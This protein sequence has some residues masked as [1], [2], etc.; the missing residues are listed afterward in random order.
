MRTIHQ[1][2]VSGKD[3]SGHHATRFS[4]K[5]YTSWKAA[6]AG[7]PYFLKRLERQYEHDIGCLETIDPDSMK[8]IRLELVEEPHERARVSLPG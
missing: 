7:M 3:C 5:V 2:C 6:K 1:L 4:R 8:I